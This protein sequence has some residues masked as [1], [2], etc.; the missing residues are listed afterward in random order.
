MAWIYWA[1][2][3]TLVIIQFCYKTWVNTTP[4][5]AQILIDSLSVPID[6]AFMASSMLVS[7][8]LLTEGDRSGPLLALFASLLAGF[9]AVVIWKLAL[10]ALG[11]KKH[12]ATLG[13]MGLNLIIT[14]ASAYMAVQLLSQTGRSA[15]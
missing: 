8:V 15:T 5:A 12:V 7:V 1:I 6:V 13:W 14:V 9:F 2:P 4:K 11:A 10:R 3:L